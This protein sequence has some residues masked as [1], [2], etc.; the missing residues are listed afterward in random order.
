MLSRTPSE[1]EAISDDAPAPNADAAHTVNELHPMPDQSLSNDY[2]T[3]HWKDW[4]GDEEKETVEETD[5]EIYFDEVSQ[6]M[7]PGYYRLHLNC[8]NIQKL[9][10]E[11]YLNL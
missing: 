3:D 7:Y 4:P 8:I 6:F 10:H 1:T 2:E 5:E 11:F 9:F